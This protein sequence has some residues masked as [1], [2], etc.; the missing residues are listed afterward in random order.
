M[1]AAGD[2]ANYMIPKKVVK[3]MGGA[4]DLVSNPEGT[5]VIVL[6]DHVNKN[7]QHKILQECALPLTGVR[8]VSQ[9]I[10]D[11]VSVS[12]RSSLFLLPPPFLSFSFILSTPAPH[13]SPMR[14]LC[15]WRM[16]GGDLWNETSNCLG[17]FHL[18]YSV[19]S[20]W[21]EKLVS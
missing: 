16:A 21:T 5:K 2:L 19:C 10:T 3:G 8:C 11:L 13:R 6:M 7:G 1:S 15:V 20:M 9:I 14:A 4:M 12:L 17:S 18:F